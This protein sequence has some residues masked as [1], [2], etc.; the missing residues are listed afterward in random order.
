M[1]S[2]RLSAA[3]ELS[4]SKTDGQI[5]A[6]PTVF[7]DFSQDVRT[8]ADALSLCSHAPETAA[9]P[10]KIRVMNRCAGSPV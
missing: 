6:A 2:G 4:L 3:V 1:K 7:A 8:P 9:R 10:E 5:G